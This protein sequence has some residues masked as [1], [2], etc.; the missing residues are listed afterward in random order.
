[1]RVVQSEEYLSVDQLAKRIPYAPQTI[2]NL[3]WKGMFIEGEHYVRLTG[4]PI[5]LWSRVEKLL[6]EGRHGRKGQG[7]S[8][9]R[10]VDAGPPRPG[11]PETDLH[12]S[13]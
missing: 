8:P 9:Y 7:R 11:T 12:R 5:F 1:M 6:M 13:S 4:R 3:M 10:P 2:R